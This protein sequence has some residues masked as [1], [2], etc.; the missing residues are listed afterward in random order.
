MKTLD[1]RQ[2]VE[3]STTLI[4]KYSLYASDELPRLHP[5][6][7]I[8]DPDNRDNIDLHAAGVIR[9]ASDVHNAGFILKKTRCLNVELPDEP[10]ARNAIIK[11]SVD[12]SKK[13]L[14][15]PEAK[16]HTVAF[17]GIGGNHTNV[18][19]RMALQGRKIYSFCSNKLDDG[20]WQMSLEKLRS[21]SPAHADAAENGC[22]FIVLSKRMVIE[23]PNAK[24]IISAAENLVG[25][26]RQ[27]RSNHRGRIYGNLLRE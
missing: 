5:E 25:S 1:D 16:L 26:C 14:A 4:S 23:Q 3:I 18:F 22:P 15:F 12:L 19:L 17:S 27:R 11:Y 6:K 2:I 9:Q 21:L 10:G 24:S 20:S 13:Q 7:T 8:P